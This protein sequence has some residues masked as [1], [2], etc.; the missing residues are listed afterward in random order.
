MVRSPS[1]DIDIVCFSR[2]WRYNHL[3]W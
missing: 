3:R 2:F 1:G